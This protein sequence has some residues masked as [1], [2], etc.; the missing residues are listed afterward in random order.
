MDKTVIR[1]YW[2]RDREWRIAIRTHTFC[3]IETM[4]WTE[5]HHAENAA[6]MLRAELG[7]DAEVDVRPK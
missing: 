3:L 2:V 1:V 5:L 7:I 6:H 4:H